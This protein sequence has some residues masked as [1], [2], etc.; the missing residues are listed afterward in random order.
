[1][2]GQVGSR[3]GRCRGGV[4][5]VRERGNGRPAT[6]ISLEREVG[7]CRETKKNLVIVMLQVLVPYSDSI[8]MKANVG[9][10]A[11]KGTLDRSAAMCSQSTR[12]HENSTVGI[13]IWSAH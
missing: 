9:K 6:C 12:S 7:C 8:M 1:M 13:S 2:E 10:Q 5:G 4:K 3:L 11:S